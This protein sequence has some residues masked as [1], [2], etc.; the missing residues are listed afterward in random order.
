MSVNIN[1][2]PYKSLRTSV[3]F[4]MRKFRSCTSLKL[5]STQRACSGMTV[6]SRF[7]RLNVLAELPRCA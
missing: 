5:A 2:P 3:F 1:D 7:A 6:M 4:P